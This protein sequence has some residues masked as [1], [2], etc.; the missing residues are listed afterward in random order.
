MRR[1]AEML[2]G[3]LFGC[4]AAWACSDRDVPP[5]EPDRKGLCAEHCAQ[6][7]GPCNPDLASLLAAGG[8]QTEGECN[9]NCVADAAWDGACRFKYGEKMTCSTELSC[10]E[11]ELH[12]TS[13]FDDPCLDAENEWAS[14]FGGGQ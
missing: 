12:Q 4:T 14:C 6:I 9:S 5:D 10:D 2:S 8:P 11:F 1:I 13:V 7:F 3:L